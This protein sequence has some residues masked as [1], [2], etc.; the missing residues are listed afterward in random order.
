MK[1]SSV[2]YDVDV[3]AAACSASSEVSGSGSSS[4]T[5]LKVFGMNILTSTNDSFRY[6]VKF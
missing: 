6:V 2:L 5:S 1:A 4:Q 3:P